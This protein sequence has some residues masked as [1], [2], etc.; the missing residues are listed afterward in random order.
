MKKYF[1]EVI[2]RYFLNWIGA[3]TWHT[4][5][6][7]DAERFYQFIKSLHRYARK[8]KF[9]EV[10]KQ[11]I[12]AVEDLHPDQPIESYK[13]RISELAMI[14]D[15][16]HAYEETPF[17]DPLVEMKNPNQVYICLRRLKI[18]SG[19]GVIKPLYSDQMIEK[20]MTENFGKDW[21]SR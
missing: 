11:L 17:P 14:A 15:E 21:E 1:S 9:G 18:D 16:I 5:H 10:E 7:S 8:G 2:D 19:K 6:P 4:D 13:E 20:I 3:S 12:R